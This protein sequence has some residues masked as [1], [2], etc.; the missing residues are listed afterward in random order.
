L[1][2][3]R[4]AKFLILGLK[5]ERKVAFRWHIWR[6]DL[7]QTLRRSKRRRGTQKNRDHHRDDRDEIDWLFAPRSSMQRV[8]HAAASKPTAQEFVD[9]V[10]I[11]T[12]FGIERA[13]V[14]SKITPM[15][16]T[17]PR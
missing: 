6:R 15:R 10:L 5:A 14:T 1:C 2:L 9:F 12:P 11:P 16:A 8:Q 7:I 13:P 3:I 17:F 4:V